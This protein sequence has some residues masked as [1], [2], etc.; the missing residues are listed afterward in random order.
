MP[1]KRNPCSLEVIKAKTSFIHGMVVS[2]LSVGK[3][4]FMG[5][6]RDTQWT[7]YWIMDLVDESK[8]ALSVM[9]DILRLLQVNKTQMS[10]QAQEEFLGATALMEGLVRH[11]SFPMRK[12]KMVMEKAVKYSEKEGRGKVSYQSLKKALTEM[13]VD[14]LIKEEDV[15][16]MQNP[17]KILAQAL[18]AGAPSEK[19]V[20]ENIASLQ[21]KAQ[22]DKNWLIHKR[23]GVE[24]AR[25]LIF[26]MEKE[27]F[28]R[29]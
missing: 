24:K 15:E 14:I 4:L 20:K 12:A 22:A 19:R 8:P 5:Y 13:K 3:A 26:Q 21:K 28:S 10:Q 27:L 7:K 23:K 29:T 16:K 6:N 25:A 17:E 2:L 9:T 1:Q 18:S 11:G